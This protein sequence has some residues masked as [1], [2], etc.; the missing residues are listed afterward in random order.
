[1]RHVFA[2][3][4]PNPEHITEIEPVQARQLLVALGKARMRHRPDRIFSF[5]EPSPVHAMQTDYQCF[6]DAFR[7]RHD[8]MIGKGTKSTLLNY[9][10]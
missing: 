8:E 9:P 7:V 5:G 4:K 6:P 1:V 2:L 10:T 3:R